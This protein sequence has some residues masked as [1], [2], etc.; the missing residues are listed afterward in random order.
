[1]TPTPGR[2]PADTAHQVPGHKYPLV[3]RINS[4][5]RLFGEFLLKS[6][7]SAVVQA[8]GARSDTTMVTSGPV[9]SINGTDTGPT[10]SFMLGF[11]DNNTTMLLVNQDSNHPA[12][13]SLAFANASVCDTVTGRLLME[14]DPVTGV[15]ATAQDDSPALPGFQVSLLAGDARLFAW[16]PSA[17]VTDSMWQ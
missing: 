8:S 4:K 12:L 14:V 6:V 5:L 11:F 3:A 9:T 15:L 10:W 1:M 16:R 2:F 13:A 7:S 17:Q